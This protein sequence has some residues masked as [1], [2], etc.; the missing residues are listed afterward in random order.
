VAPAASRGDRHPS[1][2]QFVQPRDQRHDL[3]AFD[4]LLDVR[5]AVRDVVR[6]V[7]ELLLAEGVEGPP[8]CEPDI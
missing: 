1:C 7:F 2:Y 4:G 6:V 5:D 8:P 3:V